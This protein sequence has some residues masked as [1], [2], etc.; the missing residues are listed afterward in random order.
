[1]KIP[2][3][4]NIIEQ[5]DLGHSL[6]LKRNDGVIELRC[7][8]MVTYTRE[9]V[10]ENH[11][12]IEKFADGKKALVLTITGIYTFVEP[13][14]RKYTATGPHKNF[15]AAEAFVLR[16]FMQR[17]AGTLYLRINRPIV[18]AKLFSIKNISKAELWLLKHKT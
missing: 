11:L 8:H 15:V 12:W 7:D 2:L 1:M 9:N 6:I 16:S 17:V 5:Q 18:P 4:E 10:M 14:A 3:P 13:D